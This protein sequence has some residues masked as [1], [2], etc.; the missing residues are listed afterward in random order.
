MIDIL[1]VSYICEHCN[2]DFKKLHS[3]REHIQKHHGPGPS[4]KCDQCEKS[5]S[6][7]TTLDTHKRTHTGEKPYKCSK[8]D[9][10]DHD[11]ANFKRH[12]KSHDSEFQC[13]LCGMTIKNE[14]NMAR[15]NASSACRTRR[16]IKDMERQLAVTVTTDKIE[17]MNDENSSSADQT[18][19]RSSCQCSLCGVSI[20]NKS[21]MARHQASSACQ[22]QRIN[23]NQLA[24]LDCT[25]E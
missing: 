18:L 2:R 8:C 10:T 16:K 14:R 5:F 19:I 23:G 12:L 15:H 9:H 25:N 17:N 4:Y 22:S 20:A 21:N 3:L 13:P 6:S 1:V 7:K 11:L 24:L